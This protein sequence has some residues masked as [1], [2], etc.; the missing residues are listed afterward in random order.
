[1]DEQNELLEIYDNYTT[2]KLEKYKNRGI[3]KKE[4]RS[5][6]VSLWTLQDEFITV[7]KWSDVE[8]KGRI[9]NPKMTLNVD[10]T[11]KFTFSI[12]MYYKLNG[13]LIENP[14]WYNTQNGNLIR[15][16]R[17]I[18]VIFNKKAR[19]EKVFEFVIINI[20]ENHENDIKTCEIETEGL[21]FQ[22]LGKIG[23]KISL[24][25]ENFELYYEDWTKNNTWTNKN[26]TVITT[27]PLQTLDFWC[28]EAGLKLLPASLNQI[29]TQYSLINS[30]TWYY[31]V[32]MDWKSFQDGNNRAS[33]K[34][35]EEPYPTSWNTE[36]LIPTT[37]EDYCEK[38][39]AVEIEK[40]NLYNITQTIAEKFQ[41]F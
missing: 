33:G 37:M 32:V 4:V 16:L 39:R 30:R 8:Q 35:Y 25:Q 13:K 3:L 22:E 38:A 11:E 10:G 28:E 21:A 24:S 14:N 29:R 23:Y 15:G 18:K 36:D 2:N 1:M 9:Q 19:E 5:Y 26:G 31:T 40:S 27:K 12:P 41:V 7:L 6:E 20:T 34:I 17:K